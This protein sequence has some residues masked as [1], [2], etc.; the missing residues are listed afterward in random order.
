MLLT[1]NAS[2]NPWNPQGPGQKP[3]SSIQYTDFSHVPDSVSSFC[4]DDAGRKS[5]EQFFPVKLHMMLSELEKDGKADV[6]GWSP[7][8]RAFH[9][10]KQEKFVTEVIPK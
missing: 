2:A 3:T 4:A 6:V 9:V 7:H 1:M 5:M 10:H 8:G